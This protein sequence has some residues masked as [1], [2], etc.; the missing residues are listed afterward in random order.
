M[1]CEVSLKV[2]KDS[3]GIKFKVTRRVSEYSVAETK[4]F[5]SKERALKQLAEWQNQAFN[6]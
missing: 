4:M 1:K 3:K 6:F 5:R 2:L